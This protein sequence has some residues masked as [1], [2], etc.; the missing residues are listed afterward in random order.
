MCVFI[1][2]I[3]SDISKFKYIFLGLDDEFE[4]KYKKMVFSFLDVDNSKNENKKDVNEI[5]VVF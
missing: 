3:I 5:E 1:D 2:N 4:G